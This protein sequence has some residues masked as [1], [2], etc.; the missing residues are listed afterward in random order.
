MQ[1]AEAIVVGRD[2]PME[3]IPEKACVTEEQDFMQSG[4]IAAGE[5]PSRNTPPL[6]L[7]TEHITEQTEH[8]I[9]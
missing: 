9:P 8:D 2:E 3:R 6:T 7:V 5:D 4:A 1:I